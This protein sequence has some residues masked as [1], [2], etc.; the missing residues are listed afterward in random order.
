MCGRYT[1][2][3]EAEIIEMNAIIAEVSRRFGSG[4]VKTGEIF[5]TNIAPILTM[6]DHRLA[7]RPVFWGFQK[8]NGKGVLVNARSDTAL[9]PDTAWKRDIFHK[10]LL[11]RR[12]VVPSTGFYEWAFVKAYEQQVSLFTDEEAKPPPKSPKIKLHFRRPGTTM[13]YMAGILNTFKDANGA[14]RDSFCILTTSAKH[15]IARFHERM[16]VILSPEECEDWITN[17]NFMREALARD[18]PDLEWNPAS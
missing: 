13:L 7:P 10:P 6:E 4:A 9:N 11:T 12:C 14:A 1:V 5:P 17:N 15:S 8:W 16:P 18:G 3:T 2:F